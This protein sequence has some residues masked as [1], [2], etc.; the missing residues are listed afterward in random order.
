MHSGHRAARL[1]VGSL[2]LTAGLSAQSATL[3]FDP[4][5]S[6]VE[7]SARLR[8]TLT[9]SSPARDKVVVPLASS[10]QAIAAVPASVTVPAG[11][12]VARF[13]IEIS[14][15]PVPAKVAVQVTASPPTESVRPQRTLTVLPA[16][17]VA[18]VKTSPVTVVGGA[19]SELTVTLSR[20]A[21]YPGVVVSLDNTS[22][23]QVVQPA[24]VTVPAGK[25]V[26]LATVNT[27]PVPASMGVQINATVT[28][29][30]F[31]AGMLTVQS[32]PA[33]ASTLACDGSSNCGA[34]GCANYYWGWSANTCYR[35]ADVPAGASTCNSGD[36]CPTPASAC[37]A[38]GPGPAT[39]SC[40]P[41][42]QRPMPGTCAGVAPGACVNL[43]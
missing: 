26:V 7:T 35:R 36:G 39:L 40:S 15:Q 30:N 29:A 33:E 9:L 28:G 19:T 10:N 12:A 11:A 38:S 24:S 32:S 21:V 16:A 25:S 42:G 1:T 13:V 2:L 43:H 6:A 18:S 34:I 17:A 37:P 31:V 41:T 27:A 3:T 14:N 4:E 22:A 5:T 8:A 23:G 20:Q